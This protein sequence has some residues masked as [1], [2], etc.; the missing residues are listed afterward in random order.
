M[1]LTAAYTHQTDARRTRRTWRVR[2][3]NR[4]FQLP[5]HAVLSRPV[6]SYPNLGLCKYFSAIQLCRIQWYRAITSDSWARQSVPKTQ[7][8][9]WRFWRPLGG[10]SRIVILPQLAT[11]RL[12]ASDHVWQRR[13]THSSKDDTA[14]RLRTANASFA[15]HVYELEFQLIFG[16]SR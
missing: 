11:G 3:E 2:S 16:L 5:L 6:Y 14:A 4:P 8:V 10:R 12:S 9:V 15:Q 13:P 7:L 1:C